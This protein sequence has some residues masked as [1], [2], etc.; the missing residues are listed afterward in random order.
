MHIVSRSTI[1][2]IVVAGLASLATGAA[3][4]SRNSDEF[5]KAT[6]PEK[7]FDGLKGEVLFYDTSGGPTTEARNATVF[8]RFADLTGVRFRSDVYPDPT[9]FYAWMQTGNPPPWSLIELP[10]TSELERAKAAG[11]LEKLDR[12]LIPLDQLDPADVDDYGIRMMNYSIQMIWN[13]QAF[14][15]SGPHPGSWADFYDLKKFPGKRCMFKNAQTGA[16][17]ESALL[18]DGVKPDQLYPLDVDRALKKLD[19]IKDQ[20]VW[21][22]S[23]AQGIQYLTTGECQIGVSWNGRIAGA[24]NEDHAPIGLSWN[25]ALYSTAVLAVPKGAPNDRAGQAA[26]AMWILDKKGQINFVSR[27]PYATNIKGLSLTD[28]PANVRSYLVGGENLKTAIR[29]DS[30]YY[31]ENLPSLTER[32]NAWLQQ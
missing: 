32:L 20:I 24:V 28:Y 22:S 5:P 13:T 26:I 18:A 15:M 6:F 29:E 3:A 25:Q 4:Q 9:K 11:Y 17:F 31:K 1:A 14:P 2:A 19:T 16:T 12:S 23:G 30:S 7:T 27:V 8:S 10:G 21:W